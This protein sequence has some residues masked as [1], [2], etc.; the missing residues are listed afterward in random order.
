MNLALSR[1]HPNSRTGRKLGVY[2]REYE[3]GVPPSESF[4]NTPHSRIQCG[5]IESVHLPTQMCLEKDCMDDRG[6]FSEN[7]YYCLPGRPQAPDTRAAQIHSA[8]TSLRGT[9][10]ICGVPTGGGS[11]A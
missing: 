4:A 9:T 7:V 1:S 8:N 5:L 11:M 10:I 6:Y 3:C 2:G